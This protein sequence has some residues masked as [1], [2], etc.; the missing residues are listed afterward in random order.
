M[1]TLLVAAA[2]VLVIIARVH[3]R[4]IDI[5]AV[6]VVVTAAAQVVAFSLHVLG[7]D[8]RR[9]WES[10]VAGILALVLFLLGVLA[11]VF[12][13]NRGNASPLPVVLWPV[14]LA[15]WLVEVALLFRLG[16][17]GWHGLQQR[18]HPFLVK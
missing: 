15:G 16:R 10:R 1:R 12:S 8:S 13:S 9:M 17:R 14:L 18:A 4:A 5:F 11:V 2:L 7:G 3:Q 6:L